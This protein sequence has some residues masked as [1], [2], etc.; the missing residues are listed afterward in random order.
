MSKSG[1]SGRKRRAIPVAAFACVA[2]VVTTVAAAETTGSYSYR[3]QVERY[4]HGDREAAIQEVTTWSEERLVREIGQATAGGF[5]FATAAMLHTDG[6]LR[7]QSQSDAGGSARQLET[8]RILVERLPKDSP[9]ARRWYLATGYHLMGRLVDPGSARFLLGRG[10]RRFPRDAQIALALGAVA[11]M[12]ARMTELAG[13][14]PLLDQRTAGA[15]TGSSARARAEHEIAD[16]RTLLTN[17]EEEYRRAL[18]ADPELVEAHLRRAR[19][20]ALLGR[21][22][23]AQNELEWVV[24]HAQEGPLLYLAHLFRGRIEQ[25]A[26]RLE[27]SVASY[28]LAVAKDPECQTGNLALGQVLDRL[29]ERAS[30]V[31]V[32]RK[33]ATAHDHDDSWWLYF[34]GRFHRSEALFDALR[35][36]ATR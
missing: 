16:R 27:A 31:E 18:T 21:T 6:A 17:A 14:L 5:P 23:E 24:A 15:R 9:F 20:L 33:A 26:G 10:L 2:L 30:A 1:H 12:E 8:A 36:E 25:E 34:Y 22:T 3:G 7:A 19:V 13:W 4:H 11:E 35:Q 32:W 29:G 28:R